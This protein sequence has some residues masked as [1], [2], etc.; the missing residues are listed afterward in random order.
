MQYNYNFSSVSCGKVF[1]LS[2]KLF[3]HLRS[4][5]FP[6]GRK[7]NSQLMSSW[8]HS[9]AKIVSK[10][11]EVHVIVAQYTFDDSIMWLVP[12]LSTS[13]EFDR[14]RVCC[15]ICNIVFFSYTISEKYISMLK[16][17]FLRDILI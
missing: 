9:V 3:T 1:G 13:F 7:E 12:T 8:L 17:H 5:L 2:L 15:G 6:V 11:K 16:D 10:N 14:K 4:L